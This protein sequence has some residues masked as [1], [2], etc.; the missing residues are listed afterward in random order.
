VKRAITPKPIKKAR[1]ALHPSPPRR[2]CRV[3]DAAL[4]G[5]EHPFGAQGQDQ[6]VAPWKLPGESSES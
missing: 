4:C 2:Q 5:N 1:R 3:L 6:G